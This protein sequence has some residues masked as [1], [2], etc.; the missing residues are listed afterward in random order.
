MASRFCQTLSLLMLFAA[1]L[2]LS[3]CDGDGNTDTSSLDPGSTV[4]G[5]QSAQI[6]VQDGYFEDLCGCA[7]GA[8]TTFVQ[9]TPMTCTISAGTAVFFLFS[10]DALSHQILST[11]TPTFPTCA[12]WEPSD[13]TANEV[14]AYKFQSAG[15]YTFM[16]AVDNSMSGSI[17]VQ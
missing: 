1:S 15:T 13:T 17:I 16:D 14:C 12:P 9:P 8:K 10:G 3:A 4:C 2:A 6:L 11:G 7:E 5:G